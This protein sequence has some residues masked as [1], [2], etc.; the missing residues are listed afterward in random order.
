MMRAD[1]LLLLQAANCNEQIPAKLYEYMRA[2]RPVLALTD[3]R[4]DTATTV[5]HAG[6][7]TIAKLDSID[8]IQQL[9]K[10]FIDQN[11]SHPLPVPDGNF[12]A[13]A[14]RRRR[15]ASL[16]A[17]LDLSIASN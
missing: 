10:R 11:G 8:E 5:R 14:S 7:D 15:A 17:L 13:S 2:G 6:L 16:A 4:G 1:A 12:V 3:P 9:L